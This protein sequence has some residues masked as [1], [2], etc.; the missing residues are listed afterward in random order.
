MLRGVNKV[1]QSLSDSASV[2][3]EDSLTVFGDPGIDNVNIDEIL[4]RL[5][6]RPSEH[7]GEVGTLTE[8]H[9]VQAPQLPTGAHGNVGALLLLEQ[10]LV[11][12]LGSGQFLPGMPKD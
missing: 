12:V 10:R 11:D 2:S 1:S 7:A 5:P 6:P 4:V 3:S 9:L 8:V